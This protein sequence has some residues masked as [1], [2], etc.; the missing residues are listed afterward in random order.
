MGQKCPYYEFGRLGILAVDI[1]ERI[2]VYGH[3]WEDVYAFI[4]NWERRESLK[5]TRIS[6]ASNA[7][8]MEVQNQ[9]AQPQ[10]KSKKSAAAAAAVAVVAAP[11]SFDDI[12]SHL[13]QMQPNS[14]LFDIF[15]PLESE[16]MIDEVDWFDSL[17]AEVE[18]GITYAG[19]H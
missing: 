17:L 11:K 7:Q 3:K 19:N 12:V 16:S 14:T 13:L 18:A 6:V 9:A 8:V 15:S 4:L 5:Y 10:R 2:W 1:M